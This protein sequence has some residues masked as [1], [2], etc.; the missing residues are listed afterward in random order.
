M[1]NEPGDRA[2]GEAVVKQ[3]S[4][5]EKKPAAEQ[6]PAAETKVELKPVEVDKKAHVVE[7]K[8]E[9]QPDLTAAKDPAKILAAKDPAK[10]PAKDPAKDPAAKGPAKDLAAK[11]PANDPAKDP[12]KDPA[13]KGPAKDPVYD[14]AESARA[15]KL[16]QVG[17]PDMMAT[18]AAPEH[19]VDVMSEWATDEVEGPEGEEDIERILHPVDEMSAWATDDVEGPEGGDDIEKILAF[20]HYND[21]NLCTVC[22]PHSVVAHHP[23]AKKKLED[24]AALRVAFKSNDLVRDG[25]RAGR[26]LPQASRRQRNRRRL[27]EV[28]Y[29]HPVHG[30]L[31]GGG[32]HE[33]HLTKAAEST[34]N[35]FQIREHDGVL[36]IQGLEIDLGQLAPAFRGSA[37]GVRHRETSV[38]GVFAIEKPPFRGSAAGV[39]HRETGGQLRVFAIENQGV[40]CGCSPSRN[41]RSGV[42]AIEKLPFRGCS[43]SRNPRSG[44][45][46][47]VFAHHRE[48]SSWNLVQGTH[49]FTEPGGTPSWLFRARTNK[50]KSGWAFIKTFCVPIL[51]PRQNAYAACTPHSTFSQIKTLVA[52]ALVS[53]ECGFDDITPKL[54][55]EPLVAV[56]PGHGFRINWLGLWF[57]QAD[58]TSMHNL[59]FLE[60]LYRLNHTEILK[61]AMFDVLFSQCDHHQGNVFLTEAGKLHLIDNDQVFG[62]AWRRCGFDS[63]LLPTTQKF[64]INHLEHGYILKN[65]NHRYDSSSLMSHD[66]IDRWHPAFAHPRWTVASVW[67]ATISASQLRP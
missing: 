40:S 34:D 19:L 48:T 57:D 38:Q 44:G 1:S 21:C 6:K 61:G 10:E 18:K 42:F 35:S 62:T 65:P 13:A 50:T 54:W 15:S 11:D 51:K 28:P 12:A 5:A 59:Y 25:L 39:R 24:D 37:A 29:S 63:I 4:V 33:R 64:G 26:K 36:H 53:E 3:N 23:K 49:Y 60:I 45:Q 22:V 20:P 55:V 67:P 14:P 46:L 32:S 16:F 31:S 47:R 30:G 43:P 52:Q 66:V 7:A 27:S 56:F 58:G 9:P 8:T 41:F 2:E 17:D